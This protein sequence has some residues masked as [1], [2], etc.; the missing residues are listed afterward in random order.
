M[1]LSTY[2]NMRKSAVDWIDKVPSH[3]QER[4]ITYEFRCVGSGKNPK[5]DNP[6]FYD[7]EVIPWVTS[8]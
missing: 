7:D 3:W 8:S 1:K 6:A 5:S 4:K 2:E